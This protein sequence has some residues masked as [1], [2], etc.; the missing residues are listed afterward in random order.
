M[1]I[2]IDVYH[3]KFKSLPKCTRV[4]TQLVLMSCNHS[5]ILDLQSPYFVQI[6]KFYYKQIMDDR[7]SEI[8][9]RITIFK[10]LCAPS[11]TGL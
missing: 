2:M 3:T 11:V 7:E 9:F 10:P 4:I 5:I 8:K 1:I 6:H